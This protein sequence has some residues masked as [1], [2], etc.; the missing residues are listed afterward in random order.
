MFEDVPVILVADD[1]PDML[2]L[3]TRHLRSMKCKVVEASDGD[4]ALALAKKE[5]PDLM[6]LDVMMPGKSGWEVCKAVREDDDLKDA[7]VIVLTGIGEALNAMTSPLYGADANVDKPF[8]FP[9]LDFKI[10]KVLSDR[11]RAKKERSEAPP[12]KSKA[13][14]GSK[15]V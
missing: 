11:R 14:S 12:K 3:V 5:L 4:M 2:A 15:S 6:I 7:G 13:K 9:E 10:K 8:E 1:D